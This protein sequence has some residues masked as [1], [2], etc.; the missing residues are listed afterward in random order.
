ME[1]QRKGDFFT[2]RSIKACRDISTRRLIDQLNLLALSKLKFT[3][4]SKFFKFIL[5]LSG[6]IEINPG[7]THYPCSVCE[8]GVR[9]KGVFCTDCGFW[10]HPKCDNISNLEYKILSKISSKEFTYSCSL[11]RNEKSESDIQTWDLLPFHGLS[12][13]E[14]YR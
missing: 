6:D 12:M 4:H 3:N 14:T 5:L 10:V 13:E 2:T 8:K 11:C 1:I 9:S 7:P